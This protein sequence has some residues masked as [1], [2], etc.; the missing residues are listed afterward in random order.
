MLP[1]TSFANIPFNL[2][3]KWDWPKGICSR[4][5]LENPRNATSSG[6]LHYRSIPSPP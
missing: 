6:T 4:S 5:R 1:Y 2:S 3:I